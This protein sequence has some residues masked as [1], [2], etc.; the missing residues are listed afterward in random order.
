LTRDIGKRNFL[1]KVRPKDR[2]PRHGVGRG[3]AHRFV[4]SR[5]TVWSKSCVRTESHSEHSDP[6]GAVHKIRGCVRLNDMYDDYLDNDPLSS[7]SDMTPIII[8]YQTNPC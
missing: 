1:V 6:N 5:M 7:T 8:G 3:L 4:P 2:K